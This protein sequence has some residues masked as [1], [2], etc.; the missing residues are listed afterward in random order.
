MCCIVC[1]VRTAA[2]SLVTAVDHGAQELVVGA[3]TRGQ[4]LDVVKPVTD[5]PTF[6][7]SA[8]VVESAVLVQQWHS[9]LDLA[10]KQ[11]ARSCIHSGVQ[12]VGTTPLNVAPKWGLRSARLATFHSPWHA[13]L[14]DLFR[15]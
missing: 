2:V 9:M 1:Y 10:F 4:G 7:G 5:K 6:Q 11:D 13:G 3:H 12:S 8:K 14:L 15:Y